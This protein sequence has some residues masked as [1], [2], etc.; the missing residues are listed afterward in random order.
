MKGGAEGRWN[1]PQHGAHTALKEGF[2]PCAKAMMS[3]A[4]GTSRQGRSAGEGYAAWRW[5]ES[6]LPLPLRLIQ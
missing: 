2:G 3:G 5:P 4:G 1:L 6:L